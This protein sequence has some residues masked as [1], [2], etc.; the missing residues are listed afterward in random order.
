MHS[1]QYTLLGCRLSLLGQGTE[2]GDK[3]TITELKQ[4]TL[5]LEE[6]VRFA[7]G[8]PHLKAL[9]DTLLPYAR[10]IISGQPREC[11]SA[12]GTASIT[13]WHRGHR[14]RFR[15]EGGS[16]G[17]DYDVQLDDGEL[18]NMVRC[19]DAVVH[20]PRFQL[21]ITAPPMEGLRGRELRNR[22]PL[23]RRLVAPLGGLALTT[24]LVG[25]GVLFPP[26]P[27]VFRVPDSEESSGDAAAVET[28]EEQPIPIE[29]ETEVIGSDGQE[30]VTAIV[31]PVIE[32][33]E[34]EGAP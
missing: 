3:S 30:G 8:R 33:I 1:I 19:L 34:T 21:G 4:F 24:A 6:H 15:K 14:L 10:H 23:R 28:V 9:V 7:G 26:I 5:D 25:L 32:S 27:E 22:L 31:E 17:N 29:L 12:N 18:A 11:M 20:D 13:P 16:P 2:E